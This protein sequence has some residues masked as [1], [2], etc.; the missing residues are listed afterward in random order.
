MSGVSILLSTFNGE[1]FVQDQLDSLRDQSFSRWRLFWR[2]DGSTDHTR[3]VLDAFARSLARGKCVKLGDDGR[4]RGIAGSF[5][6]LLKH[7]GERRSD[8]VVAFADQDD[9]WLPEKV[10]RGVDALATVSSDRP[11]L[12][13]ARQMLVDER[14]RTI[15]P[16]PEMRRPP[17]FPAALAQNIATGCTV[18][19]NPA[20]A[21]LVA[22]LDAPSGT[23]HDWWSYLVVTAFGGDILVD[24]IP[25]VLYRQHSGN[26][27]GAPRTALRRGGAALRRGPTEFMT[28]LHRHVAALRK[29][30]PLIQAS[31]VSERLSDIDRALRGGLSARLSLLRS[32]D[33]D[34]QTW[35][36]TT[37]FK[38]WF[39]V[40]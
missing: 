36:E 7:H 10:A 14:G 39:L 1:R 27:I 29:A 28:L 2:D 17:G 13:C 20:A 4:H 38:L 8:D 22:S 15:A 18:M 12:Y 40:G 5:F 26:A 9:I 19:L 21:A 23:L 16:S 31:L 30:A 25:T 11:A 35:F 37:V 32:L 34:R 24:G 3:D 33:L 6:W